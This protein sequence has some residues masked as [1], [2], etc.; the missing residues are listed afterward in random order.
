MLG[1]GPRTIGSPVVAPVAATGTFSRGGPGRNPGDTPGA[2]PVQFDPG[3]RR[4]VIL[5]MVVDAITQLADQDRHTSGDNPR[6]CNPQ[7]RLINDPVDV[8]SEIF[9]FQRSG[10]VAH[11]PVGV[12]HCAGFDAA[13]FHLAQ[14]LTPAAKLR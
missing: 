4:Y 1:L 10:H 6:R 14:N 11:G 13:W 7:Y 8:I 5:R 9:Q 12:Q 2:Q 3:G